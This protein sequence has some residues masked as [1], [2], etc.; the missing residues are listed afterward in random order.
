MG[1][2]REV[3]TKD[4]RMW[5]FACC[6]LHLWKVLRTRLGLGAQVLE[7]KRAIMYGWIAEFQF[8]FQSFSGQNLSTMDN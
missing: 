5:I 7:S 3:S 2:S 1:M 8:V 4:Y 6:T